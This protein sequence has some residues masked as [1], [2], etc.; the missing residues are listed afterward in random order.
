MRHYFT[1]WQTQLKGCS[2]A[3]LSSCPTYWLLFRSES[4]KNFFKKCVFACALL[5]A[6][7]DPCCTFRAKAIAAPTLFPSSREFTQLSVTASINQECVCVNVRVAWY[8][9]ESIEGILHS[10]Q[11]A[12][13]PL[14]C[15]ELQLPV[16]AEQSRELGR[17]GVSAGRSQDLGQHRSSA[18][19]L[20]ATR[21]MDERTLV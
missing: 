1:C 6:T 13:G 20:G 11:H 9:G 7:V 16:Q 17:T 21:L 19:A 4:H 3:K 12:A 15:W 8:L 2:R 10:L 5:C 14:L 18:A